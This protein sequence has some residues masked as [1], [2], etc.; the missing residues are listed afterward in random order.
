MVALRHDSDAVNK[1]CYNPHT[2]EYGLIHRA[3]HVDR[4]IALMTTEDFKTWSDSKIILHPGP[5]FNNDDAITELYGMTAA[6]Y[7]GVFLGITVPYHMK[8]SETLHTPINGY[9]ESELVYSY[10]GEHFMDTTSRPLVERPSP[11][12]QGCAQ[13]ALVDICESFDGT[14][15]ILTARAFNVHHSTAQPEMIKLQNGRAFGAAFYKIRKDGFCGLEGMGAG[16]P[17]LVLTRRMLLLEDDLTFN[18]NASCGVARFAI[19]EPG[20]PSDPDK[21]GLQPGSHIVFRDGFSFDDCV[22]FA[23]SDSVDVVP[24]WQEH[25][26][27]ELVG[28]RVYVAI[29]LKCAILHAMTG[30]V[31]QEFF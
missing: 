16:A 7:D 9:M 2:A 6:W 24:R 23:G 15:Y 5:K 10:D 28:K 29:K 11:P 22:P 21:R 14:E 1:L 25:T 8:F 27:Q 26:L 30:T 13:T 4:R 3:S 19:M 31:R 18:V 12:L 17:G 20:N